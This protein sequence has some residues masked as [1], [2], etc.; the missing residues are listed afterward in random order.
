VQQKQSARTYFAAIAR[1]NSAD[2]PANGLLSGASDPSLRC[3]DLRCNPR[4]RCK[5]WHCLICVRTRA[6]HAEKILLAGLLSTHGNK[7]LGLRLQ[8]HSLVGLLH[9]WVSG[10]C[11]G[12][13]AV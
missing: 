1:R 2:I 5:S 11:V 13:V 3:P 12:D 4:N 6:A 7:H 10:R 9:S 8:D